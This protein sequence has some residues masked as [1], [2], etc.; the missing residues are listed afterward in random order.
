MEGHWQENKRISGYKEGDIITTS[1]ESIELYARNTHP[2]GVAE[3]PQHNTGAP[4]DLEGIGFLHSVWVCGDGF[5]IIDQG[6][7]TRIK[8][9]LVNHLQYCMYH[10]LH[11]SRRDGSS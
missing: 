7:H 4:S 1:T 10:L 8:A 9:H 2:V 6:V 3:T 11:A 5:N